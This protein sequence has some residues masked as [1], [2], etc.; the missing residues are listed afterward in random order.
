LE[1]ARVHDSKASQYGFSTPERCVFGV[2]FVGFGTFFPLVI[3]KA[4]PV[5]GGGKGF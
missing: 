2:L 3:A 5:G 4:V 1:K